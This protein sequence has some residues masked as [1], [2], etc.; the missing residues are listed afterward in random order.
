MSCIEH[1]HD[2]KVPDFYKRYDNVN[3]KC[4]SKSLVNENELKFYEQPDDSANE[5]ET[6]YTPNIKAKKRLNS[7]HISSA[8]VL[9][10]S[11]TALTLN[12]TT[13]AHT[14]KTSHHPMK[15]LLCDDDLAT[16]S[17]LFKKSRS[18]VTLREMKEFNSLLDNDTIKKFFDNDKCFLV[19]DKVIASGYWSA[20]DL[21]LIF[22][23]LFQVR[24]SHG[25][26]IFQARSLRTQRV[27]KN[28]FL[29]SVVPCQRHR[30]RH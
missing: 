7:D 6:S 9:N 27:H 22:Y 17:R 10:S 26:H 2:Q 12:I 29:L 4:V 18:L 15:R 1:P 20:C 30:R 14:T 28:Q 19:T 23:S 11:K 3:I 5:Y 13:A 24:I 21:T 16:T 25:V 8:V